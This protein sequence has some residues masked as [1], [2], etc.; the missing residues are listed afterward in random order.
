M[1]L[2]TTSSIVSP[3]ESTTTASPAATQRA[4]EPGHVAAI[5]LGD[6]RLDV[7]DVAADLTD[8]PLGPLAWRRRDV[9]LE[10]GFGEH[11]GSDV[12]AL[13][14]PTPVFVRPCPLPGAQLLPDTGV[15]GDRAD[16]LGD[17]PAADL[18]GGVDP[19]DEHP[20]RR[21]P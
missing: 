5:P 6:R 7:A 8:P 14:H 17:L 12:P 15:G 3:V 20:A 11:H 18:G 10:H 19:V 2:S 9:E 16:C 1:T 4:V 13:D 21:P